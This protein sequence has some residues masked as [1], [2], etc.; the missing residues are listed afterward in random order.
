MIER[1]LLGA[2][3]VAPAPAVDRLRRIPVLAP[4]AHRLVAL[5]MRPLLGRE[6]VIP[7]GEARGL[8]I[9]VDSTSLVWAT[10]RVELP[11]QRAL[12]A[13]LRAGAV[14]YDV[15]ANVGFYTL[16]AARAV[17]RAGHVV[18]FE[19]HP[20]NLRALERNIALNALTNV[21][22]VAA[23]VT[24]ARG[25]GRLSAGNRALASLGADRGIEVKILALDDYVASHPELAPDVVK[26]DVEG[27]ELEAIAGFGRGLGEV[28]PL[29]RLRAS[30]AGGAAG[31][32]AQ[33]PWL[34]G[35]AA[36]RV[37][38]R[39]HVPR[40]RRQAADRRAGVELIE[41]AG[42]SASAVRPGVAG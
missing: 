35:R 36:W 34:R 22:V 16:L 11:V 14:V 32:R 23:A 20:E 13:S 18:A 6:I 5:A 26:L 39:L 7:E 38:P 17:G 29:L 30:R 15:G 19:P 27:H 28:A 9:V 24:S 1:L 8:R 10:G 25:R 42:R 4:A 33:P 2:L 41:R 12:V 21:T 3:R 40:A 31:S 37:R